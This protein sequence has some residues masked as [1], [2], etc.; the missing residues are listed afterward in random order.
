MR[1]LQLPLQPRQSLLCLGELALCRVKLLREPRSFILGCGNLAT[2]GLR[3]PHPP[4]QAQARPLPTSAPI[5]RRCLAA[6]VGSVFY[7]LLCREHCDSSRPPSTEI[8]EHVYVAVF[9]LAAD[10]LWLPLPRCALCRRRASRSTRLGSVVCGPRGGAGTSS[11]WRT[12]PTREQRLLIEAAHAQPSARAREAGA[13]GFRVLGTVR[14]G[15]PTARSS[16][17][18]FPTPKLHEAHAA[19]SIQA[20]RSLH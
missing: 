8:R 2:A 15:G 20:P 19:S 17:R 4:P 5:P 13:G 6:W 12:T 9:L 16:H 1:C 14:K 3:S 11:R 10:W 18:C 7:T